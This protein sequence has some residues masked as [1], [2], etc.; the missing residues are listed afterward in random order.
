MRVQLGHDHLGRGGAI[1]LLGDAD[2]VE[3]PQPAHFA[4][5]GLEGVEVH[6]PYGQSTL[7][8]TENELARSTTIRAQQR[9]EVALCQV[10]E[11]CPRMLLR[12]GEERGGSSGRGTK[13]L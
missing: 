4:L 5:D 1:V 12:L 10:D 2:L 11:L 8:R 9:V 13:L 3:L 6:L 7:N